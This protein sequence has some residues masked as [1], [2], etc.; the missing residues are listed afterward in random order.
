MTT[1]R[2]N[3]VWLTF[4]FLC[5]TVLLTGCDKIK[6]IPVGTGYAA[7]QICSSLFVSE[8][9][10]NTVIHRFVAPQL[11]QLPLL[12]NIQVDTDNKTVSVRDNVFINQNLNVAYYREGFGC[13]LLHD[14]TPDQL[15]AQLPL[16]YPPLP[17]ADAPW[18]LGDG[19]VVTD[20]PGIDYARLDA[21]IAS[22]FV[23]ASPNPANTLAIVVVHDG[24][25]IAERYALGADRHSRLVS[26]SMAKSFT[27]TLIGLLQDRGML[28][29]TEPAPIAEWAGTD[30]ASITLTHLLHMA[31]G[32]RWS[33]T[34]Q[35]PTPDRGRMLFT[36]P[37][38]A[39]FYLQ[40]PLIAEPGTTFNYSTGVTA[41][42]AR[43]V[44]DQTGG[45]LQDTY[46]FMHESLFAPL[47]INDAVL[48][49]DTVG[50]PVGGASLYI[51]ARDWAKLG[52]LYAR[53]GN[54][55]GE[56][57]LSENWIDFA[58]TPSPANPGYGA[59][60]WLNHDLKMWPY[61]PADSFAFR[62]FHQQ[63]VLVVPRYDLIVVRQGVT[64][65]PEHFDLQG[66]VTGIIASLPAPPYHIA[67]PLP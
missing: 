21:A 5:G 46:R 50:N 62:G 40:Q 34:D 35:G 43:I 37:D 3:P 10:R 67:S 30:K 13:T 59:Q 53:K 55:F 36:Q 31:P 38:H 14:A 12:W 39:A 66:L 18:P 64:F 61:L 51:T 27:A 54:W 45:S 16:R 56:Q 58:L 33:E 20:A 44:Q 9:P 49:F 52:L 28:D 65:K 25:L 24:R 11:Q 6:D 15:D 1:T 19:E 4:L 48:E 8:L 22:A 2:T 23:Q 57:L 47:G 63:I 32:L 7:K 26:W 29:V 60:I 17:S 41:L 42:L